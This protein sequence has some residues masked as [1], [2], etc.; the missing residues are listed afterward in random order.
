MNFTESCPLGAVLIQADRQP[1]R[2]LGR[3][4]EANWRFLPKKQLH[5]LHNIIFLQY[6]V[7][8]STHLHP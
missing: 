1:D 4:D 2:R 7:Q 3:H 6:I 8:C 5:V